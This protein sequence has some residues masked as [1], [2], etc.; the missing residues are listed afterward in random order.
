[1]AR[2]AGLQ[3]NA[4]VYVV[5]DIEE[6]KKFINEAGYE[7]VHFSALDVNEKHIVDI[8]GNTPGTKYQIGGYTDFKRIEA[9]PNVTVYK[10]I[11]EYVKNNKLDIYGT[12]SYRHF[13]GNRR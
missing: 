7:S 5:R 6:A 1:M 11:D 2:I 12:Y 3:R 13:K 8:I 9:F 10:S 4:D